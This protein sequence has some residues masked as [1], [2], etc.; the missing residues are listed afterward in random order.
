MGFSA[1][2][3]QDRVVIVTGAS[4]GIGRAIAVEC[5]H[6]GAHVV[7][8]SRYIDV[9]EEMAAAIRAYGRRALALACDVGDAAQ[10]Q[11]VVEQTLM[12]FGHID[13]LVNNAAYRSRGPLEDLP[14]DEW[15]AMVRINLTGQSDAAESGAAAGEPQPA[16]DSAGVQK[17][18]CATSKCNFQDGREHPSGPV[19][20]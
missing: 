13:V 5:A 17:S 12:T 10:V 11:Y 8:C 14:L 9:L 16:L 15:N 20:E 19:N 3:L 18:I 2:T 6:V 7:V 1:D 4:Q